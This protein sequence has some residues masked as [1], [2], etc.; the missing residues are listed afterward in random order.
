MPVKGENQNKLAKLS[1]NHFH[2]AN[3]MW[4]K[5]KP[6]ANLKAELKIKVVWNIFDK[7]LGAEVCQ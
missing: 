1:S 6:K 7:E 4:L 2:T 5:A 3:N